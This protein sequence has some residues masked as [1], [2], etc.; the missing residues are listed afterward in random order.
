[1]RQEI[2]LIILDE[3]VRS[4][5]L[6]SLKS[7]KIHFVEV[8]QEIPDERFDAM[9][10]LMV[11][12]ASLNQDHFLLFRR[13]K[14]RQPNLPLVCLVQKPG[15]TGSGDLR[16][17]DIIAFVPMPADPVF[18]QEAISMAFHFR[19]IESEVFLAENKILRVEEEFLTFLEV[20]RAIASSLDLNHVLTDIMNVTGRL[21]KSEAWSLA[22]VDTETDELVF[23][24][25]RGDRSQQIVGLRIPKGKGIIGW[26]AEHGEPLIV[27]DTSEDHRHLKDVDRDVGF[28]S[29][30]I[31]CVP[32]QTKG[33][34]LGAIEFINK[35]GSDQFSMEDIDRIRVFVD[36]A[37]VSIENALL[38]RRVTN[39]SERDELTGLYNQR[40]MVQILSRELDYSC[41]TGQSLAYL[42]L[43]L[44]HFKKVNDQYGHLIGRKTLTEVGKLLE[45]LT[46]ENEILGRYGGDEYWVIIPGAGREA[47]LNLAERI[48]SAIENHSFLT[49][50]G[51]NIR[52]T[53]SVGVAL[54]P[55]QAL[56]FDDMARMADEAL[57]Q[58]KQADRNKVI[59]TLPDTES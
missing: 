31:L 37:A 43:D 16:P 53:A 25:A 38:Y 23:Q 19:R 52:L 33:K 44:D 2:H 26:V 11:A 46:H 4:V 51:L 29:R 36:L 32:L 55:D 21:L 6:D 54:Y 45:T 10:V 27:A 24:A 35:V 34:I 12:V 9:E 28:E 50:L 14:S 48:R 8:S 56:T 57:F 42:F 41:R 17:D 30:S 22:L 15:E 47:A 3:A 18:L 20:G 7:S 5:C 59:C 13:I 58:A 1:M 40:A 49:E 39:M